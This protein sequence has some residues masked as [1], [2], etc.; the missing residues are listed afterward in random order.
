MLQLLQIDPI[1]YG[2]QQRFDDLVLRGVMSGP[3]AEDPLPT[4]LLSST[5]T[6]HS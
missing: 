1:I 4:L 2:S 6:R 5:D 3:L